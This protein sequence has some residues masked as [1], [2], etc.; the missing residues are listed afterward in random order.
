METRRCYG[1]MNLTDQEVCPHCGSPKDFD[2]DQ[3][4][5]PVG[6]VL[7]DQYIV[8]KVLGHGGFGITYIGWD[9]YLDIVVAI[10]EF[11]PTHAVNRDST[12][13]LSVKVNTTDM[14]QRF[15]ENRARFLREAKTLAKLRNIPQIV[16]VQ[17]YFTENNTAYIIMDYVDGQDLRHYVQQR[18]GKVP[19]R[20]ILPI[21]EPVVHALSAVHKEG[22]MHRDISPDNIMLLPSGEVILLDFGAAH[23]LE[24]SDADADLSHSTEA[25]L[26]HGFAPMEQYR[27]RGNL[28]PWTDE[29]GFCASIYY[30]LTGEVPPDAPAR[31]MDEV[32]PD[33]DS[34][35]GL[36]SNQ[37]AALKK[38]MEMRAKDRFGSMEALHEA[39]YKNVS[40]VK[41]TP[42]PKKKKK[43]L[44]PLMIL[45]LLAAGAGGAVWYWGLDTCTEV[46]MSVWPGTRPDTPEET[47][48]V[49]EAIVAEPTTLPIETTPLT[50]APPETTAPSEAPTEPDLTQELWYPVVMAEDPLRLLNI[51]KVS[52]KTVTFLDS[53]D[54]LSWK[55]VDLSQTKNGSIMGWGDWNDGYH[56]Y[57]ASEHGVNARDCCEEMFEGCNNLKTIAFNGLFHTDQADSMAYMFSRCNM[58]E[59]VDLEAFKTGNVTDMTSMFYN[60]SALPSMDIADWDVSKVTKMANLFSNCTNVKNLPVD[61]WNVAQVTDLSS[62]F[63]FCSSISSLDLS[64]WN[65]SKAEN[66]ASAFY[67]CS[68]LQ[69]LDVSTWNVSNVDDMSNMFYNCKDLVTLSLNDWDVSNVINMSGMFRSCT[70]LRKL[71]LNNWDTSSVTDMSWMF[72]DCNIL[73][74]LD[75]SNWDVSRVTTMTHM[76]TGCK[77]LDFSVLSDWNT[78]R[79]RNYEQFTDANILIDGKFW[80]YFFESEM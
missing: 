13:S 60:C 5:L 37:R 77:S 56:V 55:A 72:H 50:T 45:L 1:C 6:T 59:S 35:T 52:V 76:F 29:Y 63:Q 79:V 80:T 39:L 61:R 40:V 54:D 34:I 48:P 62:A 53:L 26:K 22:L 46:L 70:N 51:D 9:R 23:D 41:E 18:G 17:S 74:T 30:C 12:Q 10:K 25:I 58:L 7:R 66:M 68:S 44:I 38:G 43:W 75:V 49:T 3:N 36:T 15:E 32:Q 19:A 27:S 28:G 64:K 24:K 8:G 42:K 69:H 67:S 2:N 11:Y 33:W 16:G 20:E 57:I 14:A 73:T 65:T 21:L 71:E 4:Q 31:A 47:I 78:S